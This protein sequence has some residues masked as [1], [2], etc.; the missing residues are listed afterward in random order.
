LVSDRLWSAAE[1]VRIG[2]VRSARALFAAAAT[3][4]LLAPAA[5]GAGPVPGCVPH[6]GRVLARGT[7]V[8]VYETVPKSGRAI[9]AC[10]VGH[11]GHMTLLAEPHGGGLHRSLG[12]FE[13]A[14][15]MVAFLETQ[16]GV[17]SGTIALVV[18]DIGAR[19]ILRSVQAGSY[20]DAGILAR[21]SVTRFLLTARGSIAWISEYAQHEHLVEVA[22]RAAPPHGAPVLLD[23]GPDIDPNVLRLSGSMLSW[24]RAGSERTAAMP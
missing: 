4:V 16:F 24:S 3:S 21:R 22:V 23:S 20:V 6:G 5:G 13:V 8:R 18:A 7:A 14:G 10:L 17:D 11:S 2:S 19:R 9:A 15:H 1:R 12:R